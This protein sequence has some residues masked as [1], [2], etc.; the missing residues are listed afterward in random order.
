MIVRE[1]PVKIREKE[2]MKLHQAPNENKSVEL[3]E[4]SE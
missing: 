4:T 3:H 1:N 2:S